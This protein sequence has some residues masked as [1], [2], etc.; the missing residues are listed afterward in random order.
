MRK[1]GTELITRL[2]RTTELEKCLSVLQPAFSM[3]PEDSELPAGTGRE[4]CTI[5]FNTGRNR[6]VLMF[7]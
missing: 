3:L 6:Y 5:I 4:C 7:M 2:S 1:R